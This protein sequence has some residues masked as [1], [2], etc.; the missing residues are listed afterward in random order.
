MDRIQPY[1]RIY[2]EEIGLMNQ[3]ESMWKL[4]IE[5]DV[6]AIEIYHQLQDYV[7]S[8][9]ERCGRLTGN[10][11]QTCQNIIKIIQKNKAKL[12]AVNILDMHPNYICDARR[13]SGR[14]SF[15][16]HVRCGYAK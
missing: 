13:N 15:D 10:I 7:R 8:I 5:L 12:F 2:F 1:T 11:Q 6:R 9:E 4:V 16:E 14:F 3:I